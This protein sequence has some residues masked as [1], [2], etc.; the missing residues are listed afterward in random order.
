MPYGNCCNGWPLVAMSV[1]SNYPHL[2]NHSFFSAQLQDL[3]TKLNRIIYYCGFLPRRIDWLVL[4]NLLKNDYRQAAVSSPR[5][6]RPPQGNCC[7]KTVGL[8][9]P[10]GRA[11]STGCSLWLGSCWTQF[12]GCSHTGEVCQHMEI[13]LICFH[14]FPHIF[15]Y[16]CECGSDL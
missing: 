1:S 16:S 12:G 8:E 9:L 7:T 3:H 4:W 14:K 10:T 6:A 5:E 11:G 13:Y 2:L 15:A